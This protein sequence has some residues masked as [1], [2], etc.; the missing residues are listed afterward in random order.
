M[1]SIDLHCITTLQCGLTQKMLQAMIETCPTL[2]PVDDI[3][4]SQACNSTSTQELMH[5]Y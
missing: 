1:P 2:Y 5:M 3:P 4:L